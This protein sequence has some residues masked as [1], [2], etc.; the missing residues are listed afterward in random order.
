MSSTGNHH[1]FRRCTIRKLRQIHSLRNG[2]VYALM[3]EEDT[4]TLMLAEEF[5]LAYPGL[6]LTPSWLIVEYAMTVPYLR[7]K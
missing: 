5:Y 2:K 4:Y 3:N 1:R 7:H 6:R